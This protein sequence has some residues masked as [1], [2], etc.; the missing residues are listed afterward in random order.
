MQ[1]SAIIVSREMAA[2]M[3]M[4]ERLNWPTPLSAARRD[5]LVAHDLIGKPAATFPDHAQWNGQIRM[6]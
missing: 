5:C 4:R 3:P 6:E 2:K 1:P